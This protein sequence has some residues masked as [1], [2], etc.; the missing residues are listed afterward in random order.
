MLDN[1][2]GPEGLPSPE[3]IRDLRT[4]CGLDAPVLQAI[5]DTFRNLP[6]NLTDDVFA[7]TL[8]GSLRGLRTDAEEL[9][10]AVKVAVFLWERWSGRGLRRDQISDDLGSL[11]VED[12]QLSNVGPL[13]DAI[14][15][16]VGVL[17]RERREASVLRT[18]TPRIESATCVIDIRAV[19]G[20]SRYDEEAGEEQ[21]Y[22][23]FDH[24]VPAATLE[25]V[26]EINDEKLT[27]SYLL[28][29]KHLDQLCNILV[30]AKQRLHIVKR[31]M[32][33]IQQ[34]DE[35][36]DGQIGES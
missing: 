10:T 16:K 9:S 33:A 36:S 24:F 12:A 1:L 35:G 18:G 26:S 32:G 4:L 30:R 8:A 3:L 11:G 28:T 22:F 5:A 20:S 17:S 29:E 27:R 19:F 6:D 23:Q 13:L 14:E 34:I 31:Q 21:A 7:K 15:S 2:A 25:L